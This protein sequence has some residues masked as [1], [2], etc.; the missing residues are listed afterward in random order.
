MGKTSEL[1]IKIT[2]YLVM[3]CTDVHN[4]SLK[5]SN[6]IISRLQNDFCVGIGATGISR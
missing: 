3:P 1:M 5:I 6:V 4:I 2:T